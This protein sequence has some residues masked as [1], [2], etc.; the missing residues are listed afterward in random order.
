[1]AFHVDATHE[2]LLCRMP[3]FWL[4]SHFLAFCFLLFVDLRQIPGLRPLIAQNLVAAGMPG[5]KFNSFQSRKG[6]KRHWQTLHHRVGQVFFT[7]ADVASLGRTQLELFHKNFTR[8]NCAEFR[9]GQTTSG[10]VENRKERGRQV[11]RNNDKTRWDECI[12]WHGVMSSMAT[13]NSMEINK[14]WLKILS[15]VGN[16]YSRSKDIENLTLKIFCSDL[17]KLFVT[18]LFYYFNIWLI[19]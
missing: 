11:A 16:L 4:L 10:R 15:E 8:M 5:W 14:K 2:R 12:G 9:V 7:A 3:N 1:M 6:D 19:K 13:Q 18:K 17:W